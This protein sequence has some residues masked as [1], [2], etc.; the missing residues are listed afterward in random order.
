MLNRLYSPYRKLAR[1]LSFALFGL[2]AGCACAAALESAL[3]S[4]GT[5]SNGALVTPDTP[6]ASPPKPSSLYPPDI[7]KIKDRGKLIVTQYHGERA[8]FFMF[9]NDNVFPDYPAYWYEGQRLIGYDIEIAKEIAERLGVE[10]ELRREIDNFT[11]LCRSVARN[12]ADI[13]ISK[14]TITMDRAQYARFSTPYVNLRIGVLINR[15]REVQAKRSG[16]I[17]DLL[18]HPSALIAVQK[19]TSW[20]PF[21][22]DLFP[23][24][25]LIEYPNMNEALDA[26]TEGDALAFLNDEWNIAS[27]LKTKPELTLH[28]RLAF[29][30]DIRSGLA[31]AVSPNSPNLLAFLNLM[32]E[33]DNLATTPADLLTRYF[34]EGSVDAVAST[35]ALARMST[36]Q[37]QASLTLLVGLGG[38]TLLLIVFWLLMALRQP[39]YTAPIPQELYH[40]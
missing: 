13:A 4:P 11:E 29:V 28:V 33:R 7:Q 5:L 23:H 34:P 14:L 15:L 22:K 19:G 27:K 20:V 12:E 3:A 37:N 24:A 1:L 25:Q 32:I 8:G 38:V 16:G 31:M 17:M 36:R 26:V 9:D 39:K 18:N 35:M 6:V 40:D 10:L 30:P 21:G 2:H